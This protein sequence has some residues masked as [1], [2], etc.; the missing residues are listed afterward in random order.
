MKHTL[1]VAIV[2]A[3]LFTAC[4]KEATTKGDTTAPTNGSTWVFK[5]AQFNEMG[6]TTT[7][8]N[9]TLR[10]EEATV[11]GSTWLKL[12]DLS[13]QTKLLIQKRSD[14]WWYSNGSASSLWYKTS[15]SVGDTYAYIYGTC[16]V[17]AVSSSLTVPAGTFTDVTHVEGHDTNSLEDEFWFTNSGSV[18][19]R[20]DTY[21]AKSGQPEANVYRKESWTLVN[22]TR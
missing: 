5:I 19:L 1:Y 16:T 10:A 18:L 11:G 12:N 15:A 8:Q 21:D 14:G 22:Y 4:K 2:C 6:D 3:V 9:T 7:S 17:K 13:G 20:F